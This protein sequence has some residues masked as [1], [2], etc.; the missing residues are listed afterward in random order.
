[1]ELKDFQQEVL[2]TFDG[3]LDKLVEER[4]LWFQSLLCAGALRYS[5]GPTQRQTASPCSWL[6]GP[7]PSPPRRRGSSKPRQPNPGSWNGSRA[8]RSRRA[9][10]SRRTLSAY[11]PADRHPPHHRC[12]SCLLV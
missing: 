3:C 4:R 2:D 9:H 10:S 11:S 12:G 8:V 5:G 1:M 6:C 7:G